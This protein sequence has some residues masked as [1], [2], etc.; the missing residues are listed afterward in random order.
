MNGKAPRF[1]HNPRGETDKIHDYRANDAAQLPTLQ[2]PPLRVPHRVRP[3][4]KV[5]D[6]AGRIFLQGITAD[7]QA[8]LGLA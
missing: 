3:W 1:F 6:G 2:K 7:P 4:N 8:M 5:D